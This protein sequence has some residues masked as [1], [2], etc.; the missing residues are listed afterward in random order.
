MSPP[1]IKACPA[2]VFRAPHESPAYLIT[3]AITATSFKGEMSMKTMH[4]SCEDYAKDCAT[5]VVEL[6]LVRND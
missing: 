3:T 2:A 1:S 6:V 5:I 4:R